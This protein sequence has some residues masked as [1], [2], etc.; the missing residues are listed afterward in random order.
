V[1]QLGGHCSYGECKLAGA[2]VDPHM[3]DFHKTAR[4]VVARRCRA[5]MFIGGRVRIVAIVMMSDT[6]VLG[7]VMRLAG[8]RNDSVLARIVDAAA[9]ECVGG[10]CQ[11]RD[12]AMK[13]LHRSNRRAAQKAGLGE[14]SY[15]WDGC[16][17]TLPL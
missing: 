10:K 3:V 4:L 15:N 7:M 17:A 11:N 6:V 14:A 5:R 16:N 13:V 1:R 12:C 9:Q 2:N 8:S